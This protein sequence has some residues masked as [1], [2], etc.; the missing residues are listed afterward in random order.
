VTA[1]GS[2]Y[3]LSRA[4]GSVTTRR[5]DP[6]GV[7]GEPAAIGAGIPGEIRAAGD[8]ASVHLL[9]LDA[10]MPVPVPGAP[11]DPGLSMGRPIPGGSQLVSVIHGDAIRVGVASGGQVHHAVEL[12]S[13]ASLGEL[14]LADVD[15]HGGY[16]IVVRVWRDRPAPADRYQVVHVTADGRVATFTTSCAAFA[17]GA[18]LSRFRMGGDRGLYRI[19]SSP[20]GVRIARYGTGGNR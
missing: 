3:V 6:A 14:A 7:V 17:D 16:W 8:A 9:P 18:T 20:E 12:R 5:I 19:T 11:A 1:D 13:S 4:A 10:W 2:A 15:G